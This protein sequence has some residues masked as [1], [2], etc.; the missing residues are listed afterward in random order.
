MSKPP[1]KNTSST[2]KVQRE[3]LPAFLSLFEGAQGAATQAA[4]GGQIPSIG[5]FFNID[6]SRPRPLFGGAPLGTSKAPQP[7]GAPAGTSKAP[8]QVAPAQTAEFT[9]LSGQFNPQGQAAPAPTPALG[10]TPA[11][12][13]APA[14]A[15]AAAPFPA[16]A[17]APAGTGKAGTPAGQ[18]FI[19]QISGQTAQP[20][21]APSA[22]G[23]SSLVGQPFP[24]RFTAAPDPLEIAALNAQTGVALGLPDISSAALDLGLSTAQGDFL[25]PDSNPFLRGNI[26]AATRPVF[27]SFLENTLPQLRS[28]GIEAGAFKGSSRRDLGT[29]T[30]F[31]DLGQTVGDI[32]ARLVAENFA[33]ERQLQQQAPTLIDEAVR[34]AQLQPELLSQAGL[35]FRQLE[36][37][38]IE[39]QIRQFEEAIEAPFRPLLPLSNIIQGLQVGTDT[40]TSVSQ[41]RPGIGGGIQGALGGASVASSLGGG[42]GSQLLGAAAGG[43]GGFFA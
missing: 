32:S 2:T 35:G 19:D 14:L 9:P 4:G 7:A 29:A 5:S 8:E 22:E 12:T 33:R 34:L 27:Q 17:G 3:F 20:Q 43:A 1:P 23:G 28:A 42:T 16:A 15:P 40:T 37:M 36:Q 30:A 25:H 39:E 18:A 38:A 41:Q 26:E 10:G 6:P 21:E 11:P 24:G 13:T 31:R